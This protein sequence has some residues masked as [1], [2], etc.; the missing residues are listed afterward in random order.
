VRGV[1]VPPA[2]VVDVLLLLL[3]VVV[4][5][6]VLLLLLLLLLFWSS[7]LLF[8]FTDTV[9]RHSAARERRN[10]KW[11]SKKECKITRRERTQC[12]LHLPTCVHVARM[13]SAHL[14]LSRRPSGHVQ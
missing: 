2:V 11:T 12:V 10:V 6:A 5:V 7:L 8:N 13:S 3:V 4:V 1:A 14:S 9:P